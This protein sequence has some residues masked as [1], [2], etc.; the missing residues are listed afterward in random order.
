VIVFQGVRYEVDKQGLAHVGANY[1][2]AY[3][4]ILKTSKEYFES[5]RSA[6]AIS[7]NITNSIN[8]HLQTLGSSTA[9]EVFPYR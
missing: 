2:M 6:R 1:F 7:T 5:L 3:H 4:T 8:S 9:I